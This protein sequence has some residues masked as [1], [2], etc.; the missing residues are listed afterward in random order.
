MKPAKAPKK[1]VTLIIDKVDADLLKAQKQVLVEMSMRNAGHRPDA[2]QDA[3]DGLVS[4]L[5]DMT[6]QIDDGLD[7]DQAVKFAGEL[8]QGLR[9][10][11]PPYKIVILQT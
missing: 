7:P 9:R 11:V 1:I 3:L 8:I 10:C 6:D 4:L 5:D 2:E